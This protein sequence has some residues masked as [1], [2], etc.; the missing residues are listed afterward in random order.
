MINIHKTF[1]VSLKRRPD[2]R[3][4][5]KEVCDRAGIEFEFF[6]AV[7]GLEVYSQYQTRLLPGALG[8]L[9]S[10]KAILER[11]KREGMPNVMIIEDDLD[12]RDTFPEESKNYLSMIPEDWDMVYLGGKHKKQPIKLTENLYKATQVYSSHCVL[13]RNSCYDY[14]LSKLNEMQQP[15]DVY[16]SDAHAAD[17]VAYC[18]VPYLTWQRMSY[19]DITN[20]VVEYKSLRG[21]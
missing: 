5:V 9:L 12:L 16:Y 13:Y 4:Q 2:R 8:C 6:D 7:D 21:L 11:A 17:L 10:H 15:V 20:H 18:H 1:C 19:S 14:L 3:A